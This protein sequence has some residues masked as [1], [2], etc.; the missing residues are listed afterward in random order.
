MLLYI[1]IVLHLIFHKIIYSDFVNRLDIRHILY[2]VQQLLYIPVLKMVFRSVHQLSV[3]LCLHFV[4]TVL[5]LRCRGATINSSGDL[6][7]IIGTEQGWQ[8]FIF[9]QCL[10]RLNT[11]MCFSQWKIALHVMEGIIMKCESSLDKL[12]KYLLKGFYVV[13]KVC[14]SLMVQTP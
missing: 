12:C 11:G 7:L 9:L 8:V 14:F 3:N 4:L 6:G 5:L 10:T 13:L 2:L 1:F